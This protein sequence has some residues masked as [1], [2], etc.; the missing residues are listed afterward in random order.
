[1][2]KLDSLLVYAEEQGI[3]VDWF[4]MN[5]A[6]SLSIPLGSD[7]YGIAIDPFKIKSTPDLIHKLAHEIGHCVTGSFY[8]R[9]SDFDCC[10]KHENQADKWAIGQLIPVDDL[11]EAV[12]DG[13][14]EI[15]ELAERF[16]VTEQF[17]KKAVCYYVHGNV[18]TE[19]YF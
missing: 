10:Q 19:L 16:G 8:N 14:T 13:C 17:M 18:A 15:W 12:A 1:M 6:E 11:D 2:D 3:D 5:R 7:T 9:Y 4:P